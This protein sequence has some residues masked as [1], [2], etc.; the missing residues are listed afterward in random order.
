[1]AINPQR[2]RGRSGRRFNK[3]AGEPVDSAI[4][5]DGLDAPAAKR[6]GP[7]RRVD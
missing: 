7:N 5:Y 6:P 1:M 3:P 4:N 2:Q